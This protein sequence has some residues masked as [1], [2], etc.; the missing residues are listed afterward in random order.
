V[1]SVAGKN[2]MR[3][4][5]VLLAMAVGNLL[6]PHGADLIDSSVS[7]TEKGRGRAKRTTQIAMTPEGRPHED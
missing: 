1:I 3:L 4:C 6:A 2:P 5:L 7:P